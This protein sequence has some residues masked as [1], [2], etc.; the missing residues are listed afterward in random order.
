MDELG[1]ALQAFYE[2]RA[3]TT[4]DVGVNAVDLVKFERCYAAPVGTCVDGIDV[5]TIHWIFCENDELR[6][7]ADDGFVGYLGESSTAGIIV[8][9]IQGIRV[10]QEFIAK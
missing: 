2:A 6:V 8:E 10:L 5:T 3:R 4:N 9:D 1:E 7:G